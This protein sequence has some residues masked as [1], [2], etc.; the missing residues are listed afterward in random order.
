[1]TTPS[2]HFLSQSSLGFSV[3]QVFFSA[4]LVQSFP[5]KT[6]SWPW[7][8]ARTRWCPAFL[9]RPGCAGSL[10]T[11]LLRHKKCWCWARNPAQPFRH[12]ISLPFRE[13]QSTLSPKPVGTPPPPVSVPTFYFF[14]CPGP[15]FLSSSTARG[16]VFLPSTLFLILSAVSSWNRRDHWVFFF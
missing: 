15:R 7:I 11:G 13:K 16:F 3:W 14:S 8:L 12:L 1:V 2:V 6:L 4:P 5:G 9:R 10:F